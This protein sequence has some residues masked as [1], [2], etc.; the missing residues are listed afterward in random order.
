MASNRPGGRGGLDI[1]AAHRDSADDPFDAPVNLGPPINT[2]ADEFCPTPLIN[3]KTLLF[4]STK[5]GGCGGSD[6]YIAREH[7]QN[8]WESSRAPWV[9]RQQRR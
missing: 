1:W 7:P 8:G 3:G 5:A 2:A 6:I 9:R 4:V